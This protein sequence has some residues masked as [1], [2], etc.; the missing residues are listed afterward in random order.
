MKNFLTLIAFAVIC[1]APAYSYRETCMEACSPAVAE[2]RVV[3]AAPAGKVMQDVSE[4][5][6]G[7]HIHPTLVLMI[8][9]LGAMIAVAAAAV[10]FLPKV[11]DYRAVRR[12]T[13]IMV[14]GFVLQIIAALLYGV[15]L[16]R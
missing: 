16:I 10:A 3:A 14:F 13:M 5:A 8:Y 9:V 12:C 6:D 4:R 7:D 1:A 15:S 2:N 11:P